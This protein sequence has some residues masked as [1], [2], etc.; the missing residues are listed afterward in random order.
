MCSGIWGDHSAWPMSKQC[1]LDKGDLP[2]LDTPPAPCVWPLC[3]SPGLG[4]ISE[5]VLVRASYQETACS[6]ERTL[7]HTWV[8]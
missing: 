4:D 1:V 8:F 7:L 3:P 5:T 6:A 2:Q